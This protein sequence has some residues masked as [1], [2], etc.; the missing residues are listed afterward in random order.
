MIVTDSEVEALILE[1]SLI[2]Q[3]QPRYN[4]RLKDDKKF[5]FVRV[6]TEEPFPRV[7]PT[8][9]IPRPRPGKAEGSLYFGPYTNTKALRQAL[10][11]LREVFPL[12]TCK[13]RIP[14]PTRERACLNFQLHR[15]LAP[16][17][18]RVTPA[19]Y[20]EVLDGVV[21]FLSGRRQEIRHGLATRMEEA[22]AREDFELAAQLRDQLRA[23][24]SAASTQK[25]LR[26]DGLSRDI[27]ALARRDDLSAVAVLGVREGRLTGSLEFILK[28][29]REATERE[30][31]MSFLKQ[32]Y[33]QGS[34]VPQVIVLS[35]F[36]EDGETLRAWLQERQPGVRFA[37]PRR[38][39]MRQL[40]L[41][42]RKNAAQAL[43][44][45]L[46]R[47]GPAS[48]RVAPAVQELHRIL[49]LP[50]LPN[51]IHGVDISNLGRTLAVGSIV[52]FE[53]GVPKRSQY[54]R[55]RIRTL[56]GQDDFAMLAEVVRRRFRRL[57]AEQAPLPD[58]LLVDGGRGQLN[59]ARAALHDL[60]VRG[61]PVL[62]LAKR[63]DEIYVPDQ[64]QTVMIPKH[65]SAL[66]LLQRVRDEAHRFAVAYHRARRRKAI[67]RSALEDI[68]GVG[69]RRRDVLLSR[70]GSLEE[71]RRASCQQLEQVPGF[72]RS[73]AQAVFTALHQGR[74]QRESTTAD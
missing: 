69:K 66:H 50:R 52:V 58:L 14:A 11:I 24:E 27:L 30:I 4:I 31:L 39:P 41:M 74:A 18:G 16:C 38:G 6:T 32:Y 67:S 53:N 72:P 64:D 28:N 17:E 51:R 21:K 65:L 61:Q 44:E 62:G 47:S 2:K 9:T 34:F 33:L 13:R 19:Q 68:P 55:F 5:P 43:E 42:G 45:E 49:N 3:H 12:R 37:V 40:L 46:L 23:I 63:L 59:A 1:A 25:I 36:P 70:F 8:R 26:A 7:F 73:V 54:R 29:T 35:C 10:R 60:G 15:C 48:T 22:A 71:V 57:L 56:S 20:G